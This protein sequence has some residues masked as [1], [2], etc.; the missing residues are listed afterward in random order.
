MTQFPQAEP[1]EQ[2][3]HWRRVVSARCFR[4]C[5]VAL[6]EQADASGGTRAM[7]NLQRRGAVRT[8]HHVVTWQLAAALRTGRA[9]P[10]RGTGQHIVAD[11]GTLR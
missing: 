6:M 7:V 5:S 8:A 10:P 9:D 2:I 3:G 1:L 11:T 4:P